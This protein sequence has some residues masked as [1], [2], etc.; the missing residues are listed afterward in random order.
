MNSHLTIYHAQ[1]R[2]EELLREADERGHAA[3]TRTGAL[4]RNADLPNHTRRRLILAILGIAQLM[5]VLDL[6]IVTIALPSAQ[7]ALSFTNDDRQWIVTAYALAFG[8]LLLLGG[9]LGDLWGRKWTLLAGLSGFALAS[10]VGGAA[11]SFGMLAAARTCQGGFA[12]LLAP[13]ALSLLTTTFTERAERA[14][15]FGVYSAIAGSG[16]SIGLLLGGVLT[17][18]L[19]WRFCLYVNLVFAAVAVVG[20]VVLV[21][22]SRPSQ[23]PRLDIPGVLA[24]S[25]GLFAL[26]FGCAHAQITSWNNHLTIGMIV[27]GLL[28]LGVFVA[29]EARTSYALLPLRVVTDR[30]R[31]ASFLSIGIAGAA[32]FGVFLFLTY[33]LQDVRGFSPIATGLAF[34]PMSAM[35]MGAAILGQ[36]RLQARFGPRPLVVTGMAL[37]CLGMLVLTRIGAR[38]SYPGVVL[39][40]LVLMGTGLGLVISTSMS[41][42]TLGVE[43]SDAGVTSAT[44][45]AAQQIGASLGAAVLS[46]IAAGAAR[47][48]VTDGDHAPGLIA[49]AAVHGYV[50][51]F[52]WAAGIFAVGAIVS[53][54]LF[55]GGRP[56][57]AETSG[58]DI[59]IR[60]ARAGDG[61]ALRRLAALDSR[62]IPAPP[63]LV[64][65]VEGELRAAISLVDLALVA[66]PFQRTAELAELLRRRSKPLAAAAAASGGS[67]AAAGGPTDRPGRAGVR[68]RPVLDGH[69]E[70]RR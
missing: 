32:I 59:R 33:Y 66:D 56:R 23:R 53:A 7:R 48:Y 15:A 57:T 1:A 43:P 36:T 8:S 54:A 14:K 52:S 29:L 63:V 62:P 65:E 17:E 2:T 27:T 31:G 19:S 5:V 18:W 16:A 26:V 21:H 47:H 37:G 55:T 9:R 60:Y 4:P 13:S 12:A 44:V 11:Q 42:A 41:N 39:P 70:D 50:V 28:L 58:D 61:A 10:A 64:A 20:T 46:T 51:G 6:T 35:A 67:G 69:G 24:V 45:S 40:A 49:H 25:C 30:T 22:D 3:R 38:A 34:L 68:W